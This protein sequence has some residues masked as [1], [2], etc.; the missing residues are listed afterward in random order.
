MFLEENVAEYFHDFEIRE[1]K[2]L[3]GH[4]KVLRSS[5][6]GTVVNESD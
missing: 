6:R 2:K 5:R 4:K 1:K 3:T